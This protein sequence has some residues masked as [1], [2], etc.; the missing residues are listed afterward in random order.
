MICWLADW[1]I[2]WSIEWL[3]DWIIEWMNEFLIDWSNDWLRCWLKVITKLLLQ[4]AFTF[5][6][7]LAINYTLERTIT[8]WLKT[9]VGKLWLRQPWKSHILKWISIK[10]HTIWYWFHMGTQNCLIR[11]WLG[12]Y[13]VELW[14]LN[15]KPVPTLENFSAGIR[16]FSMHWRN[17]C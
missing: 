9:M 7:W 13:S 4:K 15:S 10:S 16:C 11:H 6:S 14:H 2:E 1:L 8:R 12:Q 17:A 5:L 3:I